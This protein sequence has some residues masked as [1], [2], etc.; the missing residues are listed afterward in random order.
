MGLKAEGKLVFSGILKGKTARDL[1]GGKRFC[2]CTGR[3]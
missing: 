1:L 3:I 2:C